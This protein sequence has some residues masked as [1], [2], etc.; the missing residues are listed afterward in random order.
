MSLVALFFSTNP[1]IKNLK[2][3]TNG[4]N[5]EFHCPDF[6]NGNTI[7][8]ECEGENILIDFGNENHSE[9][10]IEYLFENNIDKIDCLFVSGKDDKYLKTLD[11][12][13]NSV[14][15]KSIVL[16]SAD[17]EMEQNLYD[18]YIATIP[19]N[20]QHANNGMSFRI[21]KST[22]DIIDSCSLSIKISFGENKF[23][24]WN[25]DDEI[26]D[27]IYEFDADVII[28]GEGSLINNNLFEFSSPDI[29]VLNNYIASQSET[30][31]IKSYSKENYRTDLNGDIIV[32]SNEVDIKIKC[33]NK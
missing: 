23:L 14:T 19:N 32:K 33:E 8:F 5:C 3:R 1:F 7:Y 29:C 18:D 17:N 15:V 2:Y 10:L 25:S 4:T 20:S 24:I 31:I 12:L 27:L 21:G 11:T 30:D 16:P 9:E 22:V 6:D 13:I 26:S 28:A